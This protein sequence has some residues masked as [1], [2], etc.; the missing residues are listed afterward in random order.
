MAGLEA[1]QNDW[2]NEQVF[3]INK[4]PAHNTYVPYASLDQAIADVAENSPYQISLNGTWKFNWVRH[5][6]LRPTDFYDPDFDVTYWDDLP[7]PSNWQLHGY[8]KPI[9]SNVTYPFAKDW[10]RIM[11]EVP[12]DW[13]KSELPNP[14]GSYRR[15]FEIPA[16]WEGKEIFLHFAGVQ[17]AMY[18]WVNG[19]RIGY[20]QGSMT[21]AEFDITSYVRAGT[22]V[23]AVEVYRW[24][25]GSYLEDQDFWRLSGIYRDVFLYATPRLHVRDFF[26]RSQL[27]ADFLNAELI[28]DAKIRN[29]GRVRVRD[30]FLDLYLLAEGESPAEP[31]LSIPVTNMS[32]GERTFSHSAT[33]DTPQLWSAETP[34]LYRV[35]VVLRNGDGNAAEV[36]GTRFGFRSIDIRD[37]QLWVNGQSVLLK[38]ANRHEI[39]PFNGRAVSLESMIEDI[40]LMKRHNLNL[41]RTSHYPNH[42]D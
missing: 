16:D 26:L 22:N 7:V 27:S 25:D 12:A 18:V 10:P 24:S 30:A 4:E 9:Y 23:L 29:Y 8:G 37:Q 2:E 20:S 41:V 39:D 5:P 38:G 34:Q 3:G 21:P 13:T 36:L 15:D 31:L 33:V 35:I 17:S 14:V 28:L 42:P 1:Q 11:T 40:T 19:Q 32:S 6:D